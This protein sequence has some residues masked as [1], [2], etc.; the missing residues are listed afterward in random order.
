MAMDGKTVRGVKSKGG[1]APHLVAALAHD[2][3]AVLGQGAVETSNEISRMTT[4]TSPSP[5][6]TM[7]ATRK[8]R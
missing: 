6:A 2:I 8:R 5:T 3:G 7:P 4:R 1:K